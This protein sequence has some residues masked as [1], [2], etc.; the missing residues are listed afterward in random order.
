MEKG[1][2]QEFDGYEKVVEAIEISREYGLNYL[3]D[4]DS[5]QQYID[6]L[7]PSRIR[8]KVLDIIERTPQAKTI[9]FG[10]AA[11]YLP[12]FQA[13]Q[14]IALFLESGGI[15]TSRPYSISSPPNQI[16][17]YDLTIKRVP[18]GLASGYLLDELRVGDELE[19]SGPEGRFF[20]NPLIH[21]KT[22]VCLAGGSGVTPFASM[23]REVVERGLDREIHLFYGNKTLEEALFHSLLKDLSDRFPN[24]NYHP[25][26]EDPPDGFAGDKGFI[27]GDLI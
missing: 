25:V 21:D 27:T 3:H 24:V 23:I 9:R 26:L 8:L 11:G 2:W 20:F 15:R 1:V 17:Y 22:M 6:R 5:A 16:G 19:S 13:G 10:A 7:H 18:G 14:Y 4:V 12:P